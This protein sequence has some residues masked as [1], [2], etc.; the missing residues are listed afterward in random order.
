M[1]KNQ[2]LNISMLIALIVCFASG[3]IVKVI[4]NMW[5]GI[6]HGVSGMILFVSILYHC[7]THGMFRK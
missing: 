5:M 4:P 6:T 2:L 7:G 3:F 1:R